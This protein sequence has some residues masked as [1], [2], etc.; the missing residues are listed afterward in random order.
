AFIVYMTASLLLP[1]IIAGTIAL[2]LAPAVSAL[3]RLRLP[4]PL[5]AGIVMLLV[6]VALGG[7]AANIAGPVQRWIET[8]PQHLR[9]LE[10]RLA[11]LMRPVEAVREATEK[12]S[13]I[14]TKEKAQK[15]R[16]V[17]LQQGGL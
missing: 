5:S 6:L 3:N 4:Q 8:A 14:A 13:E 11:A 16:E 17:V 1:I 10:H 7:V 12:V 2:L 9:K 15:P